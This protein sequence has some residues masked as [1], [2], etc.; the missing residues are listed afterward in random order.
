MARVSLEVMTLK[1]ADHF[2]PWHSKPA[3]ENALEQLIDRVRRTETN[4]GGGGGQ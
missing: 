2:I 3:I 4:A 1:N